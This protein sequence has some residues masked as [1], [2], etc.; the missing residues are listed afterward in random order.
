MNCFE[1]LPNQ[2]MFYDSLSLHYF[3]GSV[4]GIIA[5]SL[6]TMTRDLDNGKYGKKNAILSLEKEEYGNIQ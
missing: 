1:V 6:W 2:N 4:S 5:Q 3:S